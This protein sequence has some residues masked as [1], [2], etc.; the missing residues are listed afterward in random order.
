[1]KR[2]LILSHIDPLYYDNNRVH[3]FISYFKHHFDEVTVIYIKRISNSALI[4]QLRSFFSWSAELHQVE[5]VRYLAVHPF[6]ASG[7]AEKVA[8]TAAGPESKPSR[9]R[10]IV[11]MWVGFIGYWFE[12]TFGRS[13]FAAWKVKDG[14]AY[15][16]AIAQCIWA[17]DCALKIKDA[18][19]VHRVVADDF[20]YSPGNYM[21]SALRRALIRRKENQ[22]LYRCDAIV[23]VGEMLQELRERET[24]RS[25]VV[26]PNGMDYRTFA[27]AHDKPP[28]PP[29][30]VYMGSIE[31]WSGLEIV[32]RSLTLLPS[33]MAD[34]HFLIIGHGKDHYIATL[35]D[36]VRELSLE[37]RVR[38]L[39]KLPH[40]ELAE[41]LRHADVGIATF[42]PVP[43]RKYAASL[44]VV[45]YLAAGVCPIVTEGIQ[46]ARAVENYECGVLTSCDDRSIAAAIE[47]L[48]DHPDKRTQYVANGTPYVENLHWD[49]LL[50]QYHQLLNPEH[51]SA[52]TV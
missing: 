16:V 8:L 51:H 23:S 50:D 10:Q 21:N 28:H 7:R 42:I 12:C 18:G 6:F 44:K 15:D 30:V 46:T 38:F 9:V 52:A 14:S 49:K 11:K 47:F 36:R 24:G 33:R 22:L 40:S 37:D 32:L 20:D 2:L 48:F 1:M 26:I 45:E 13:L 41:H 5:N 29:T 17:I 39:G 35:R 3:H 31:E 25:V 43:L 27:A 4:D 34:V 19:A